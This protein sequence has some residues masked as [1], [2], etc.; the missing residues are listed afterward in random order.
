MGT[1]LNNFPFNGILNIFSKECPKILIN[2]ENAKDFGYDFK[3]TKKYP[4]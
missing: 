4:E 3:N 2:S 1:L